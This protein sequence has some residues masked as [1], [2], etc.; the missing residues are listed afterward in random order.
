MTFPAVNVIFQHET[1][2]WTSPSLPVAGLGTF[3]GIT[4][5]LG[6]TRVLVYDPIVFAAQQDSMRQQSG[7]SGR[8]PRE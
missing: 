8:P 6:D 2:R 7:F 5:H 3:G 4:E 1:A